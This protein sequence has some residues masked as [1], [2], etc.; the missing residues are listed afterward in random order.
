MHNEFEFLKNTTAPNLHATNVTG[1]LDKR[2]NRIY[3]TS[4]LSLLHLGARRFNLNPKPIWTR[5]S[6]DLMKTEKIYVI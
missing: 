5:Q 6:Q 2:T 3:D 4:F 1:I